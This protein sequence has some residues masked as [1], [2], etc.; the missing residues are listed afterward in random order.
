MWWMEEMER[1]TF[2]GILSGLWEVLR[3]H[4]SSCLL[5]RVVFFGV[6]DREN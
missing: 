4:E 3:G 5:S 2:W 1:E 6:G